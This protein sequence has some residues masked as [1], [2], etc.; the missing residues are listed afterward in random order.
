MTLPIALITDVHSNWP[1]LDVVLDDIQKRGIRDIWF[2]G[3]VVDFGPWPVKCLQIVDRLCGPRRVLGNHDLAVCGIDREEQVDKSW[4]PIA[5]WTT[6]KLGEKGL[7]TL[8]DGIGL[9]AGFMLGKLRVSVAHA[10][11]VV[12]PKVKYGETTPYV[13]AGTQKRPETQLLREISAAMVARRIDVAAYGHT[14]IPFIYTIRP[15]RLYGLPFRELLSTAPQKRL[16]HQAALSSA[17]RSAL[18]K[19]LSNERRVH[20]NGLA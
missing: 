3:D 6:K 10:M 16:T 18:A 4:L 9:T 17:S 2:L 7:A 5:D 14:H 20:L 8:R 15:G 19:T 11:P 12:R 13:Y 1:A